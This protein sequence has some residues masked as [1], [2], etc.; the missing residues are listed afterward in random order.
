MGAG[1]SLLVLAQ[2]G[3]GY[4]NLL[5]LHF[6]L[7]FSFLLNQDIRG[8]LPLAPI[9]SLREGLGATP[10]CD[11][12]VEVRLRREM[13]LPWKWGV[14]LGEEQLPARKCGDIFRR[15]EGAGQAS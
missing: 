4:Q 5:V 11:H 13:L 14:P 7:C 3:S 9:R 10:V 6:F 8:P 15:R 12:R 1:L 2:P